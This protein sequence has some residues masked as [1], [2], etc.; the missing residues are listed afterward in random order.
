M[1]KVYFWTYEKLIR[2][3]KNGSFPS[4]IYMNQKREK[5]FFF[6]FIE[7]GWKDL[8]T[9]IKSK[10]IKENAKTNFS[11]LYDVMEGQ[12]W[13]KKNRHFGLLLLHSTRKKITFPLTFRTAYSSTMNERADI[14][15]RFYFLRFI[16]IY[17]FS[18]F[19]FI[20]FV[21][22]LNNIYRLEIKKK[23]AFYGDDVLKI[24]NG[25]FC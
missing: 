23:L 20:I 21:V 13:W 10:I 8:R 18:S 7:N 22:I 14:F 12:K 19:R 17:F 5:F 24:C 25:I 6:G 9:Q 15:I 1:K 3:R 16:F 11:Y 2:K 4:L